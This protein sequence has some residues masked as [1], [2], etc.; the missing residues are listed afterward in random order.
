MIYTLL[1]TCTW[2]HKNTISI[3][4]VISLFDKHIHMGFSTYQKNDM[5]TLQNNMYAIEMD[6]I[7]HIHLEI[8]RG[9]L[10][11]HSNEI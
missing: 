6:N 3:L 2:T 8:L 10:H 7:R 11:Y 4:Q 1:Y 5:G 9:T